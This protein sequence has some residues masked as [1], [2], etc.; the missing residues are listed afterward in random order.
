MHRRIH[1]YVCRNAIPRLYIPANGTC[2]RDRILPDR[3]DQYEEE[4]LIALAGADRRGDHHFDG[5]GCR[6]RLAKARDPDVGLYKA[7]DELQGHYL[8][9]IHVPVVLDQYR[10]SMAR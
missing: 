5:A 7:V 4:H 1:L 10:G 9:A 2:G 3:T 8:P 6:K